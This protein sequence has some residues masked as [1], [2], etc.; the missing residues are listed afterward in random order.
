VGKDN[1]YYYDRSSRLLRNV[2]NFHDTMSPEELQLT[3]YQ[4]YV[5][6]LEALA[7]RI[8][9][10]DKSEELHL[11]VLFEDEKFVESL[12]EIIDPAEE[13]ADSEIDASSESDG[14]ENELN[15]FEGEQD[16]SF[17][18]DEEFNEE[19]GEGNDT[20]VELIEESNGQDKWEDESDD[21][22]DIRDEYENN[23]DE[24]EYGHENEEL[25]F[26]ECEDSDLP[27][28]FEYGKE[29]DEGE[30]N[31]FASADASAYDFW[32]M[33]DDGDYDFDSEYNY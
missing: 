31:D 12:N 24:A 29:H 2:E 22:H 17:D 15:G 4:Q 18:Q 26:E 23:P 6:A 30:S 20:G 1:Y 32:D 19:A 14:C 3:L 28:E 13:T 27:D 7:D 8:N 25:L 16:A 10:S 5:S 11:S 33:G 21:S 9:D